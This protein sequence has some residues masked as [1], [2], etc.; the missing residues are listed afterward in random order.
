MSEDLLKT[1]V[2]STEQHVHSSSCQKTYL[3]QLLY[4]TQH[5]RRPSQHNCSI[6]HNMSEDL[7][8]TTV[9]LYTACQKTFSTQL[10]YCT[11]HVRRPSQHN[12]CTV[13][14]M[15][16]DLLNTTVVLYTAC[17]KTFSTQLLYCTQHV[18]R[19]SQH[20][21]STDVA[22]DTDTGLC[23]NRLL[24]VLISMYSVISHF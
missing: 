11:Q 20:N 12:C 7:L 5:V 24:T 23:S 18:R 6:V 21:C 3:K 15:S 8:N 22:L 2:L 13:H 10:L 9:V 14:S 4:C 17:Q 1:T 19:P 16:E